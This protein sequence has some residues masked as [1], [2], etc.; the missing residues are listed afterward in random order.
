M[1]A[2]KI[3]FI[4]LL[5]IFTFSVLGYG[6]Y[7][8]SPIILGPKISLNSPQ[9][10]DMVDGDSFA[11]RG[12][13]LRVES[14]YINDIPTAFTEEGDFDTRLA[15]YPGSNLIVIKAFD[16]FNRSTSKVLNVGTK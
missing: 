4:S 7:K 13:V 14:L 6:V 9:D 15:V 8:A 10:G 2:R 11:L 12:S 16:K 1:F 3:F 5:A